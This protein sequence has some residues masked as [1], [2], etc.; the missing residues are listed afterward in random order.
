[1]ELNFAIEAK[2]IAYL[3]GEREK[4]EMLLTQGFCKPLWLDDLHRIYEKYFVP[5]YTKPSVYEA[6][7]LNSMLQDL[8]KRYNAW[9]SAKSVETNTNPH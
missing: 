8:Y 9:L 5:G 2:D 6:A 4:V 1:M 7:R 3:D